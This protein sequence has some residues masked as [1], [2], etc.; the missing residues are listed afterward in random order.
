M[1]N[2]LKDMGFEKVGNWFKKEE[3]RVGYEVQ[4]MY[5]YSYLSTD[6]KYCHFYL[7]S[8]LGIV[9]NKFTIPLAVTMYQDEA[10]VSVKFNF[11][12][13]DALNAILGTLFNFMSNIDINQFLESKINERYVDAVLDIKGRAIVDSDARRVQDT[14]LHTYKSDINI[15]DT[16]LEINDATNVSNEF[17]K[18]KELFQEKNAIVLVKGNDVSHITF[19]TF[20]CDDIIYP[21]KDV[22]SLIKLPEVTTLNKKIT[23]LT[24]LRT[25]LY[26]LHYF[27]MLVSDDANANIP[28]MDITY[29]TNNGKLFA[30]LHYDESKKETVKTLLETT[31]FNL[32]IDDIKAITFKA[33][34]YLYPLVDSVNAYKSADIGYAHQLILSND[35]RIFKYEEYINEINALHEINQEDYKKEIRHIISQIL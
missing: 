13:G 2:V 29:A 12:T 8:L 17:P 16:I 10:Y 22:E 35:K 21:I 9:M 28:R 4:I 34:M 15:F 20:D 27:Q 23:P 5:P 19:E 31:I 1:I 30:K 11:V 32:M 18:L 3:D 7:S 6:V 14:L 25:I 33:S 26:I 24:H